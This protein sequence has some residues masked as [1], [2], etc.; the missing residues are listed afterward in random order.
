MPQTISYH[1]ARLPRHVLFI[2]SLVAILLG[3]A[4][5]F[6]TPAALA[7]SSPTAQATHCAVVLAPLQPGQQSSKILFSQCAAMNQQVTVPLGSTH[8]MTWYK[9][10]N[11]LPLQ[12]PT[13]FELFGSAGPCD[14][15]GYGV[16]FVGSAWNDKISSF[17]VFNNCNW[18]RAYSNANFNV[19][20]TGVVSG[21]CKRYQ[22]NTSFVG[23]ALNDQIS[24][25][26]ITSVSHDC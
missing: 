26:R 10:A 12:N 13:P 19:T 25:F 17:K 5:F 14:S 9:D 4:T 18:T 22:G 21:I 8:L 6:S 23:A 7:T 3:L 15:S 2:V 24:S 1:L 16:T 11:F 20:S